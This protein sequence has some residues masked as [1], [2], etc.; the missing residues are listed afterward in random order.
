[1]KKSGYVALVLGTVSSV[2][3][4]LGMCM[5]LLKEWNAFVPGIIAGCAG[6]LLGLITVLIWRRMENIPPIKVSKKAMLV[7]AV[8]VIGTLALGIGMCFVMIWEKLVPGII[9]GLVGIL[10]FL[11][12][13]PIT[14]EL[15]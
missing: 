11:C 5:A 3:F 2:L 6:L 10:A 9:I 7:I 12:L 14:K 4:A 1:M 13:I 15:K 8:V